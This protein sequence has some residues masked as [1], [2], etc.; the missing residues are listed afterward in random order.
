[1]Q[2]QTTPVSTEDI[3]HLFRD[4][5][6]NLRTNRVI[7]QSVKQRSDLKAAL[8]QFMVESRFND[9][10]LIMYNWFIGT[11]FNVS[12]NELKKLH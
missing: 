1:M 7:A 5:K 3:S 8:Q 4:C 6:Q 9:E 10:D 2:T 11:T 12:I